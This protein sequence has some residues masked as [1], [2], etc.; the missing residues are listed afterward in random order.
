LPDKRRE[1]FELCYLQEFSYRE[2]AEALDISPKTVENHMGMALKDLR[3]KL[4]KWV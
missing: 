1:V 3:V 4:S 2:A